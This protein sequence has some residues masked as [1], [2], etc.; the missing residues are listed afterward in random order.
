MQISS[1]PGKRPPSDLFSPVG[2]LAGDESD[3]VWG[4]RGT[5]T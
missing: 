4:T 2:G 5:G 3:R 1:A